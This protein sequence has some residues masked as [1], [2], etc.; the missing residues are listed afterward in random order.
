[1]MLAIAVAGHSQTL[2][3]IAGIVK[4]TQGA[5]IPG[6]TVEAASP[7]LIEK[8]RSVVTNE[9]GQYQIVGLPPGTYSVTFML[10][11][12]ATVKREEIGTL[13]NFTATINADLR[14]GGAADT[15]TVTEVA[16]IVDTAGTITDRAVT[17]DL[18][19]AIPNGDTMYQ[20]AAMMPGVTITGGQDVGGSSGSP[21]GAQLSAHGGTGNDEVQLLDGVRIGNMMGGSRTQQTLSPLLY[22]EVDVQ[23]SGQGAD[24]VSLGVTS[25]SIPRSGGNKFSGTLFANGSSPALQSNNLTPRLQALGLTSV[26]AIKTLY[27]VNGSFGGPLIRDR[28]WFYG[29]ERYQTNQTWAAGSYYSQNPL[30]TPG[31]LPRVATTQQGYNPNFIWDNTFRLTLAATPKLRVNAFAVMQRK[32]WPYFHG[33]TSLVSPESVEQVFWPGRLY[34]MSAAYTASSRIFVEGGYNYQD[35]SDKWAPEPFANNAAGTAVRVTE[36][37]TT[38]A[39]GTVIAPITYGPVALSQC[40]RRQPDAHVRCPG[41]RELRYGLAQFQARHGLAAGLP[42]AILVASKQHAGCEFRCL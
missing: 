16:P 40:R 5:V 9:S 23:I 6:V 25:N 19:R 29:T 10:P 21:V 22:D 35:S 13:A 17:P 11:G 4:D 18:I 1:M 7:A 14:V 30:P 28:L 20:L 8:T 3:T 27:D 26:T 36:Q 39:D 2:G 32:W 42:G 24:A 38:L 37:G 31:N 15:I 34:Q 12:F 33:V 41:N